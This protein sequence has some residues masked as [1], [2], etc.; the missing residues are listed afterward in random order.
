MAFWKRILSPV[1]FLL[2]VGLAVGLQFLEFKGL[3]AGPEGVVYGWYLA[4][5]HR[6]PKDLPAIVTV[7][8][9]DDAYQ[10]CF[11]GV[12]PLNPD[13]M[14]EILE[15]IL[16]GM[17]PPQEDVYIPVMG[18]DIITDSTSVDYRGLLAKNGEIKVAKVWAAAAERSSGD[19]DTFASWFFGK[20]RKEVIQPTRVLGREA[21]ALPSDVLWAVPSYPQ[22][23]DLRVRRF[24]RRVDLLVNRP[25]NGSANGSGSDQPTVVTRNSWAR[26]I[27]VQHCVRRNCTVEADEEAGEE[28]LLAF[29]GG[30][31]RYPVSELFDCS[32]Q[33]AQPRPEKIREM[34]AFVVAKRALILLGGTFGSARDS[35]MTPKGAMPGLHINAY[36]IQSEVAHNGIHEAPRWIV[37]LSDVLLGFVLSSFFHGS[38][39]LRPMLVKSGLAIAGVVLLSMVVFMMGYLWLTCVGIA[40][41]KTI[42]LFREIWEKDPVVMAESHHP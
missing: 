8:I 13:R 21:S 35:Y 5:L 39:R 12:S 34:W 3:L 19:P 23:E 40:F 42:E 4:L 10:A 25:V 2:T 17:Q 1:P 22:D 15:G 24:P 38:G 33:H 36:A 9:D 7:E 32:Q 37:I 14:G 26:E 41:G 16:P 20:P 30:L 11:G 28:S 27:A 6:A 31:Q 18:V 29:D